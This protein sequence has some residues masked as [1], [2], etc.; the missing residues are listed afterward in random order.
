LVLTGVEVSSEIGHI[1]IYGPFPDFRDFDIKQSL[2]IFKEIKS[3]KHFAVF[4]HPFLPKNPILDWNY[5]GFDA[6]EIFNGDSQ[7]RDDSFFDMLYVLIG[8]FIYKNPL[9]FIVDYPEKNVKKW[10]ELLNERKIFQIG[11][12]D[13]HANIK[14]SKE[15]SIKF[16]RY[17]QILDFT[18][19]HIITKEKLSGHAEKDKYI[20]FGCLKEGRCYTELGNFTDPEGFVFKGEANNRTVYSGDIIAGE[21]TFSVI[22]PDTSDIVIRLYNKDKLICTSNH[23]KI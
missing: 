23:H 16:P 8:S 13:A 17:E 21:V 20:I 9:N 10:S 14:I 12:V 1:L 7:W 22:L 19:T 6:L 4:C 2:D 5:H 11:S 18:K 15:R 3:P